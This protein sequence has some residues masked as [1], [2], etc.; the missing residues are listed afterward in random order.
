MSPFQSSIRATESSAGNERPQTARTGRAHRTPGSARRD[1]EV[2]TSHEFV[3]R[4]RARSAAVIRSSPWRAEQ[5][6]LV[7][8]ADRR[9]GHV[10]DVEH[11]ARPSRR[12]RR[13]GRGRRGRAPRRGSTAIAAS[14]R[15][16]RAAASRSGWAGRSRT[17]GRTRSRG[18]PAGPHADRPGGSDMT[19]RRSADGRRRASPGSSSSGSE[20]VRHQPRPDG[21]VDGHAP[22]EEAAARGD[23]AARHRDAG[24]GE[25]L[26]AQPRTARPGRAVRAASSAAWRCVQTP[27]RRAPPRRRDRLGGRDRPLDRDAAAPEPG[28]DLELDVERRPARRIAGG[29]GGEQGPRAAPGRRPRPRRAAPQPTAASAGGTG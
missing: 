27:A 4:A 8:D 16:S 3:V 22:R 12:C 19:G 24:R 15:R 26:R 11:A 10:G 17:W 5:H 1:I 2:T 21:V 6:E 18:R 25:R 28:L 9:T 23:V 29:R 13:A 20:A 7:V 14:R